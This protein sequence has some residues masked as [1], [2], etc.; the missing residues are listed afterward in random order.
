MI[1]ENFLDRLR[2]GFLVEFPLDD[3]NF[4]CRD[5]NLCMMTKLSTMYRMDWFFQGPL[6]VSSSSFIHSFINR[7]V[8]L[9]LVVRVF[10]QKNGSFDGHMSDRR[11]SRA[12][13]R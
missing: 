11:T 3:T 1:L 9:Y 10:F 4:N 8:V 2:A 5:N 6:N 7:G 12:C 13:L